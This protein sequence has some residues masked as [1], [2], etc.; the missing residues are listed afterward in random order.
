MIVRD[1]ETKPFLRLYQISSLSHHEILAAEHVQCT[2]WILRKPAH[3]ETSWA[4]TE[5]YMIRIYPA[6]KLSSVACPLEY[7]QY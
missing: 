2:V 6:L 5:R 4:M 1:V 7:E 3:R